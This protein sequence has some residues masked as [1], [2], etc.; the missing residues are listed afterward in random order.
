MVGHRHFKRQADARPGNHWKVV[1]PEK[2]DQ[3]VP[4]DKLADFMRWTEG[5]LFW[6]QWPLL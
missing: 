6:N 4:D 3:Q 2:W 1:C 5:R